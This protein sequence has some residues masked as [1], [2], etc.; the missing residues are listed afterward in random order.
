MQIEELQ[1]GGAMG[2][3]QKSQRK[4]GPVWDYIASGSYRRARLKG[5][6]G[7]PEYEASLAAAK[8]LLDPPPRPPKP[9]PP[10]AAP[11]EPWAAQVAQARPTARTVRQQ[12]MPRRMLL[13]R[14][15]A[16]YVGLPV[17]KFSRLVKARKAP[18]P[19]LVAG[20]RSWDV[21][22]LDAWLDTQPCDGQKAG[23]IFNPA[24]GRF[25]PPLGYCRE[26]AASAA[27]HHP[28]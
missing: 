2:W 20:T 10:A 8:K 21:H 18:P 16:I 19:R 13:M 28:Q 24:T 22:M 17:R 7:T 14:E 26:P 27:G 9:S 25:Y 23:S 15:A 1:E 12:T 6:Q 11:V 4:N 3:V 5:E